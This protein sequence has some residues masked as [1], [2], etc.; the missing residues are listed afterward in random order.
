[1]TKTDFDTQLK[2]NSGRVSSSESNYLLVQIEF[3]KLQ[4]FDSNYF[5]G[6][7]Y[8]EGNYLIFRQM[9]RYFKKIGNIKKIS[10]WKS[11]KLSDEVLKPPI[12]NN[13]FAPKL[14]YAGKKML[15]KFDG[16]CLIK[17]DEF[18]FNKKSSKHIHCL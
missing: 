4:K 12:N 18:R 2:K 16:S 6:K 14:E 3:K 17:Q 13:S 1:M 10:S 8:L 7:E 9:N 11:K 5:R 15:V